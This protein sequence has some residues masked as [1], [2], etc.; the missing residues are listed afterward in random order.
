M[1]TGV[2]KGNYRENGANNLLYII[3]DANIRKLPR[4]NCK[5]ARFYA[6][7]ENLNVIAFSANSKQQ[8]L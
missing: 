4:I 5:C 2:A 7:T 6:F 8:F 1:G 3:S